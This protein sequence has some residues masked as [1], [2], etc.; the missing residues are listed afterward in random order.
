MSILTLVD[1]SLFLFLFMCYPLSSMFCTSLLLVLYHSNCFLTRQNIQSDEHLLKIA[2]HRLW[3]NCPCTTQTFN[4]LLQAPL[5]QIWFKC[6]AL[7]LKVRSLYI[8]FVWV[9]R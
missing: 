1:L 5:I 9:G 8:T 2:F 3:N 7:W 4:N 6:S